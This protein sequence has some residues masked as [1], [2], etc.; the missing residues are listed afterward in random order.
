MKSQTIKASSVFIIFFIL[1]FQTATAQNKS[2]EDSALAYQENYVATHGVVD[3]EDKKYIRFFDIDKS[4][5]VAA[6]F[7][8]INDTQGF[9]MNTSSGVKKNILSM[10]YWLS[11]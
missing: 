2:Y 7:E 1:F 3:E 6:T 10:A 11:K 4:Y 8:K 5:C 9:D